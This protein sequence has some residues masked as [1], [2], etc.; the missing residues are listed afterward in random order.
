MSANYMSVMPGNDPANSPLGHIV[1]NRYRLETF[2]GCGQLGDVYE[3][4]DQ[5]LTQAARNEHRV[6]L[7]LF[8]LGEDQADLRTR[9]ANEFLNLLPLSHPNLAHIVDF[10][11]D[12]SS[13]FF[14]SE[15]LEGKSLDAILNSNSTDAFSDKEILAIMK[16]VGDVLAYL[17]A[18]GVI[19]G[20]LRPSSVFITEHFEIKLVDVASVI[21]RRAFSSIDVQRIGDSQTLKPTTDVFGLAAI[22]YELLANEPP[23]DGLPRGHARKKELKARRIKGISMHR[24]SALSRALRLQPAKRTTSVNQFVQEFGVTGTESLDD[25]SAAPIQKQ[26][27]LPKSLVW[28]V[29]LAIIAVAIQQNFVTVTALYTDLRENITARFAG[30][31]NQSATVTI[32]AVEGVNERIEAPSPE[33]QEP[34][35]TDAAASAVEATEAGTIADSVAASA[36]P[37]QPPAVTTDETLAST[38]VSATEPLLQNAV[39][40]A[41]EA[42][43]AADAP[44]AGPAASPVVVEAPV[45]FSFRSERLVVAESQDM[46]A[47]DILRSGNRDADAAVIWWTE[48][49]SAL[50]D[51]DYADFGVRSENFA[52]GTAEKTVYIPLISDSRSE[53]REVFYVY[54]GSVMAPKNEASRMEIVINDDDR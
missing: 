52:S 43:V 48:D 41:N 42:A 21:L 45:R 28:I 5:Q 3:A 33:P 35:V 13:V 54:A 25:G 18:E 47:V 27:R 34:P 39:A 1:G 10:G 30:T 12:G 40:V 7:E 29:P 8:S 51:R 26:R 16:N 11:I 9:L 6:I 32:P 53:N 37:L 31:S 38:Q 49:G 15:L 24:W 44:E 20:D 46:V 14:T 50:A 23:Y 17:H 22:A 4:V 19:H 2:V 36:T